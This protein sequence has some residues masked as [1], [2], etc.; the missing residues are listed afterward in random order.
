MAAN[1]NSQQPHITTV[2][3]N[4][5]NGPRNLTLKQFHEH[6]E[7]QKTKETKAIRQA[8][9]ILSSTRSPATYWGGPTSN[10][11]PRERGHQDPSQDESPPP[12]NTTA[13]EMD[14]LRLAYMNITSH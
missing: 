3:R 1:K 9:S 11:S 8:T 13:A 2:V 4:S 12:V 7:Q 10:L 6:P 5:K 14:H